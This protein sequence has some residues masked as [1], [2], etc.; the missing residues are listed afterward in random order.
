MPVKHKND[1]GNLL[2]SKFKQ[3]KLAIDTN[4]MHIKVIE[5]SSEYYVFWKKVFHMVQKRNS[6]FVYISIC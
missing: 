6:K 2:K 5:E 4:L 1:Q 3:A